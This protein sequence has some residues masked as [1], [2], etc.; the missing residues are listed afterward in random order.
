MPLYEYYCDDCAQRVTILTRACSEPAAA[1]YRVCDGVH[2]RRLISQVAVAHGDISRLQDLSWM[3]RDI[4]HRFEKK[5][6]SDS[7]LE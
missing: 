3:D 7:R 2:L 1:R 6:K 4:K 5:I